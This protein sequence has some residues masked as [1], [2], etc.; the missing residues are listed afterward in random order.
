MKKT[1]SQRTAGILMPL[2]SLPSDEG[3]G[4]L[5]ADSYHFVDLLAEMGVRV[6]QLLPLTPLGFGN[7]PYQPF[8]SCAGDP[9]YISLTQL[10][11]DG[12]LPAERLPAP[13]P[14]ASRIDYDAVRRE[15]EPLLRIACDRFL[16]TAADS[17]P[18]RD[19]CR[20]DWVYPYAV[21]MALK[22]QNGLRPWTEWPQEQ[23]DW[24]LG[25]SYDVG[26]LETD[27][28]R[29]AAEQYFFFRQWQ[30][31]R[32]YAN[33]RG[34]RIMG[35][36]PFYVGM[37]SLEAWSRRDGFLLDGDGRPSFIAGVPPDYFNAEGQR[38]GNPIYDWAHMEADGFSFWMDR[39]RASGELYDILRIDH[40]RA[41]DTYWK[42]P[43]D[44]PTAVVGEWVCAPGRALF[45]KIQRE[46]PELEIVAE[47]LGSELTP[48]VHALR[49]DFGLLGMNIAD[50]T[51]MSGEKPKK[52]QLVYTGTHDN[53]TAR[54]FYESMPPRE[55]TAFR[56]ALRSYGSAHEPVSKK[57]LRYVFLSEAE[58]A[59]VPLPDVLNLGDEARLNTPGT[60]GSPNWEWRLTDWK[61][62]ERK[63]GF[64]KELIRLAKRG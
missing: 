13:R 44:S 42:I 61:G 6:W 60:V 40:F 35:D 26:H 39:L 8:A 27:I 20:R 50:F 9:L 12:L 30:A 48:G 33:G 4:C 28:R 58:M 51:L 15:K 22:R 18:F 24:I 38:W 63:K 14:C 55:R 2:A 10:V 46:L 11:R 19:F 53:Q 47:D 45:E 25:R 21:F 59:V 7:S 17:A 64:M 57:L 31:L 41:F 5:G 49:D 56:L 37:D 29:G 43:A 23:R 52:R 34:V 16:E 32:R 62:V 36:L 1:K 3:I 54:G